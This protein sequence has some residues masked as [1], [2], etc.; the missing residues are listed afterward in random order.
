MQLILMIQNTISLLMM[1]PESDLHTSNLQFLKT[2]SLNLP[3]FLPH[4]LL[5]AVYRWVDFPTGCLTTVLLKNK[6]KGFYGF[7]DF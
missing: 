7:F 3:V 6:I 5:F 1:D 4:P 2:V